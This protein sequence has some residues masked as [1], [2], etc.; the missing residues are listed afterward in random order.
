M[1]KASG[2]RRTER[3]IALECQ[4]LLGNKNFY[5]FLESSISLF[6]KTRYI[7]NLSRC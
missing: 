3:L 5:R 7:Q 2:A 6:Q 1:R 4:R